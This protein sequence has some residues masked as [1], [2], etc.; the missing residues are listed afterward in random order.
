MGVSSGIMLASQIITGLFLAMHYIPEADMAFD[1]V[2]HIVVD[3]NN[4]LMIRSLHANGSSL[5]FFITYLHVFRG[6][7]YGSY[8]SP[9][10]HV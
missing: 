10:R 9:R 2:R 1:S 7:Y 5:F 3:V 8:S 4:G 6:L